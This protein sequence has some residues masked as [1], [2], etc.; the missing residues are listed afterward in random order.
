MQEVLISK[1][2]EYLLQ[3][4]PDIIISFQNEAEATDYL[5]EKVESMDGLLEELMEQDKP[6]YI[7]EEICMA[8]LT[9]EFRPS[10]YNYLL[11]VLEEDFYSDYLK[12]HESGVLTYEIVSLLHSCN[13]VFDYL[14]FSEENE[15]DRKIRYAIIRAIQLHLVGIAVDI[16]YLNKI[17]FSHV[18]M[19]D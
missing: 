15:D 19:G 17:D 11:P 1:L 10:R 18:D 2:R 3:N 7:I 5:K 9:E 4:N 8:Q 6:A 14:N 16:E 12:W 13:Q